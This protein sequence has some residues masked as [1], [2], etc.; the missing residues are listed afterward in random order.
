MVTPENIINKQPD[1]VQKMFR[2]WTEYMEKNISFGLYDSDIHTTSHCERVL[3]YALILGEKIFKDN[4]S[5]LEA[6]AHASIFHDTRRQDDYLDKGHGARA[7]KY[8]REFCENGDITFHK[9]AYN[10]MAFHDQDDNMGIEHISASFEFNKEDSIR[11]YKIFK[12][13]DAL[14][15][16]RLGPWGLNKKFLRNQEAIDMMDFASDLVNR[17]VDPGFLAMITEATKKYKDRIAKGE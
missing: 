5:Y 2:Y 11:L 12:D 6:L 9:D 3:L 1:I 8:Y 17:T 13:S 4:T 14:D 15:R 16:Y 10:L 7:A